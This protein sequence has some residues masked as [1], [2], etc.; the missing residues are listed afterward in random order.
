MA[1]SDALPLLLLTFKVLFLNKKALFP[2]DYWR[3]SY[4]M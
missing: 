1:K 2:E 4:Y 3:V